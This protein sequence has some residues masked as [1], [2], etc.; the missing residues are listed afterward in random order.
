MFC[1]ECVYVG[2]LLKKDPEDDNVVVVTQDTER[3]IFTVNF[4]REKIRV[5]FMIFWL[6]QL[7]RQVET[8]GSLRPEEVVF[9]ALKVCYTCQ[10]VV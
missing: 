10:R 7:D 1:D 4:N 5:I 8:T 6:S 3:F 9:G 2:D